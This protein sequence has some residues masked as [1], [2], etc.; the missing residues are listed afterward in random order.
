MSWGQAYAD[1]TF[2]FVATDTT[3]QNWNLTGT[4]QTT[5]ISGQTFITGGQ[6]TE[7][8][9]NYAF[10]GQVFT[11]LGLS[12]GNLHGVPNTGGADFTYDNIFNPTSN[13]VF[14]TFGIDLVTPAAAAYITQQNWA[15]SVQ[16]T[17]G[18]YVN[19]WSNG[20]GAYQMQYVGPG[21]TGN[22]GDLPYTGTGNFQATVD[23]ATTPI[24]AAAWLLGS[25]LMGVFGFRRK[26]R[27]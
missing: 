13:A 11:V 25:G 27:M 1:Y 17:T 7:A 21:G 14:G 16:Q 10:S 19:I 24:P 15:N 6:L 18:P 20:P 9:G 8:T 5:E 3:G 23:V 2:S 22:Q 26:E 12:P 4:L